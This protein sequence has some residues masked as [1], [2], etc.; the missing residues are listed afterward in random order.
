MCKEIIK[1]HQSPAA[2]MALSGFCILLAWD[3]SPKDRASEILASGEL[4]EL[5]SRG[6]SCVTSIEDYIIG[7]RTAKKC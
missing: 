7:W 4:P 1:Q 6:C 5:Q 2:K 3:E